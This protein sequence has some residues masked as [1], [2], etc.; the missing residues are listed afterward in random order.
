MN[1]PSPGKSDLRY[2]PRWQVNNRIQF[3]VHDDP[4]IHEARSR[5]LSSAGACLVTQQ[6]I[7]VNQKVNVKIYLDE[8]TPIEVQGTTVWNKSYPAGHLAGILFYNTSTH[9]QDLILQ[10]AFAIKHED[11]VHQWF[12]GWGKQP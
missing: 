11:V 3:K 6:K 2:L 7:P 9:I 1:S 12:K 5:D 10:H 8:R 4:Q